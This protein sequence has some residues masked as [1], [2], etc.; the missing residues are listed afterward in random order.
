MMRA[1]ETIFKWYFRYF[2]SSLNIRGVTADPVRPATDGC[3]VCSSIRIFYNGLV[4]ILKSN[5]FKRKGSP[6]YCNFP[7]KRG[8]LSIDFGKLGG[9]PPA[10]LDPH[11]LL[12]CQI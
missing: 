6:T 11:R 10:Y 12:I 2:K 7:N 9:T 4:Y 5:G 1:G 8:G 3:S